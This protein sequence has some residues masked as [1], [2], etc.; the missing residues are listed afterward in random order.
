M[1]HLISLHFILAI[2]IGWIAKKF[3]NREFLIWFGIS[4][5]IPIISLFLLFVLGDEGVY[6]P[7]CNKKNLKTAEVCKSCGLKLKKII[8]QEKDK[9][10]KFKKIFEKKSK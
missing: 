5:L 8:G 10:E 3:F 1:E 7:H 9:L 4:I 2:L 6:C